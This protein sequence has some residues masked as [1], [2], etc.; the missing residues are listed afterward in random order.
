MIGDEVSGIFIN[1]E[2]VGEIVAIQ[3]K[4]RPVNDNA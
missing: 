4:R 2:T 3:C 1:M